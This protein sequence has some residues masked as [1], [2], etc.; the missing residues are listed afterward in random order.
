MGGALWASLNGTK[1][2]THMSNHLFLFP[3]MH[4]QTIR[5]LKV[6]TGLSACTHS[7]TFTSSY[8]KPV[9]KQKRLM[10]KLQW[11]LMESPYCPSYLHGARLIEEDL[12]LDLTKIVSHGRL[13]K[14]NGQNQTQT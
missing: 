14:K 13:Q 1:C 9:I 3:P 10:R 4:F 7:T 6:A 11:W 2:H 5:I 8:D 12:V